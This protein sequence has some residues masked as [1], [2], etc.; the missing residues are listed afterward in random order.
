MTLA[1]ECFVLNV[2]IKDVIYFLNQFL[3]T[4][5]SLS[6][7]HLPPFATMHDGGGMGRGQEEREG[8]RGRVEQG[9]DKKKMES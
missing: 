2:F 5:P 9:G 4:S 6:F 3:I 1:I 8:D 7:C